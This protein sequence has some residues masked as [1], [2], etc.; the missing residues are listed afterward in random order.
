MQKI[1]KLKLIRSSPWQSIWIGIWQVTLLAIIYYV[2]GY[3]GF[4]L[5]GGQRGVMPIPL[6][7]G[8]ALAA[9]LLFSVHLWPGIVVGLFLLNTN[10]KGIPFLAWLDTDM[11]VPLMLTSFSALGAIVQAI[12]ATQVLKYFQFRINL[13]RVRDTFLFGIVVFII[14]PLLGS[15]V[16]MIGL[17]LENDIPSEYL[18]EIW[19]TSWFN[20]GISMLVLTSTLLVWRQLP[21]RGYNYWHLLEGIA[22][23]L[24]LTIVS[25]LTLQ[26]DY[27]N[28]LIFLY[29]ILPFAVWAAVRFQQHGATLAALVIAAILLSGGLNRIYPTGEF[30]ETSDLLLEIGFISITSFTTFLVAAA[31]AERYQAEEN[32]HKE[33]ELANNTLHSIADAVITTDHHGR[34][35]YL[36]PVAEELIGYTNYQAISQPITELFKLKS[37]EPSDTIE[38]PVT[39]C[40]RGVVSP[41]RQNILVNHKQQKIVI[42][43]SV[44][45]IRDRHGRIEGVI[46]VFHDVSKEHRL[47][48]QLSHQASHDALTGL[49]NRRE[50]EYQLA[51]LINSAKTQDQEHSFLYLD[52]DQFKIIND[53]KG[54]AAGDAL[55]KQL[56]TV[57]QTRVRHDDLFARLGGDEFGVLL[58]DCSIEYAGI[59]AESYLNTVRD[60]R[61]IWE[62]RAVEIG[63]SIGVVPV[64]AQ[65]E[66]IAEVLS[67]ADLACYAAKD[68]GR[69]CIHVAIGEDEKLVAIRQGEMLWVSRIIKAIEEDRLV[70]YKQKIAPV[71]PNQQSEVHGEI[72]IRMRDEDGQ[73][74]FPGSFLPAAERYNLMPRI[75]RWVVHKVFTHLA[76]NQVQ[77]EDNSTDFVAINLSGATLND[78][79]FAQFIREELK[80]LAVP[81]QLVCFEITETTAISSLDKA[82]EFMQEMSQLGFRFALDDFGSG[83]SSFGY[84]KQLPV[85]YLKLDGSFVKDMV[86][87]PIDHAIVEAVTQIGHVM[88]LKTIAEWVENEATLLALKA[89]GVD[90][91]Q[92]FGISKPEL[93]L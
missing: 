69:N 12:F 40:L 44:A 52:L 36:N 13:A 48:E 30:I 90:F 19:L 73:I 18:S 65:T 38:N 6:P 32:L 46:M 10:L 35:T 75:D 91:A 29:L 22:V 61:F 28:R 58:K 64:N 56:V 71:D 7:A 68:K 41:P 31:Y 83:V 85:N 3:V 39:H 86:I 67:N 23:L 24:C 47:R 27:G 76:A 54:H 4:V 49:C 42:E 25:S 62:D 15:S 34:I 93:F 92:G 50:F 84:L 60:F 8:I 63:V 88:K 14:A 79:S 77:L 11:N 81:T 17:F 43:N 53:T 33:K 26:V 59:V 51:S 9:L 57:L 78:P 1:N 87:D 37:F 82:V 70:L 16:A 80:I 89:I 74:I 20:D 55:L 66:N 72:L 2:A 45:P 5:E 21:V